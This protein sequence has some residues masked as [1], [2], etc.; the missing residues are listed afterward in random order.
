[1][2]SNATQENI[3]DFGIISLM[4]HRFEENKYPSTNIRLND[5]LN[6]LEIIQN[7]N[8]HFI[9]PKNYEEELTSNKKKRKVLLTIDDGFLSFYENAWPVLKKK[10]IPFI[11]FVNTREVG[12]FNYMN[13]DQIKEVDKENFVEMRITPTDPQTRPV[14]ACNLEFDKSSNGVPKF[15]HNGANYQSLGVSPCDPPL[16]PYAARRAFPSCWHGESPPCAG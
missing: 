13:W 4:Y 14:L 7:E 2:Y 1:M 5:F 16:P 11:L 3:E 15:I 10:K 8:I 6:H 12:S 9:D